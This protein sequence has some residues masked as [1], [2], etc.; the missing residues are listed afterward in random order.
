MTFSGWSATGVLA[1]SVMMMVWAALKAVRVPKQPL[2]PQYGTDQLALCVTTGDVNE[3]SDDV[4][5]RAE[6]VAEATKREDKVGDGVSRGVVQVVEAVV[7][8]CALIWSGGWGVCGGLLGRAK[9]SVQKAECIRMACL[10]H[11]VRSAQ[12]AQVFEL[13]SVQAVPC[14]ACRCDARRAH[15]VHRAMLTACGFSHALC[16]VCT[17]HCTVYCAFHR[18]TVYS[19]RASLHHYLGPM[20]S[21]YEGA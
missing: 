14:D 11:N 2:L 20:R 9:D 19:M 18:V 4:K 13:S 16:V 3:V 17:S 1:S 8:G 15:S 6:A 12:G 21:I 5:A 10:V 7:E